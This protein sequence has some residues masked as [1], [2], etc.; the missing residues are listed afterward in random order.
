MFLTIDSSKQDPTWIY[1]DNFLKEHLFHNKPVYTTL[2]L[3]EH[4]INTTRWQK[5]IEHLMY[6]TRTKVR[7]IFIDTTRISKNIPQH[8]LC[9]PLEQLRMR[10]IICYRYYLNNIYYTM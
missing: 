9:V 4:Y 8:I 1:F 10:R 5:S 2:T 6:T 3:H 7:K